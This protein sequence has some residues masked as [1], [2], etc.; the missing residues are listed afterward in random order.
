M[1]LNEAA[2]SLCVSPDT[3]R[4]QV[5]NGKLRARKVGPVWVVTPGEVARY[6]R[7]S[8]GHKGRPSFG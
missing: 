1:T 7:D 5:R 6:R 3:L 2:A 8:L 4:Q